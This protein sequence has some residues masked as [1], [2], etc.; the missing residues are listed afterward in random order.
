MRAAAG[1][2]RKV[3]D[4]IPRFVENPAH[5]GPKSKHGRPP[6]KKPEPGQHAGG[7]SAAQGSVAQES[8]GKQAGP[9][10]LVAKAEADDAGQESGPEAE[11]DQIA[12]RQRVA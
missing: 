12:K 7:P 11:G 3:G 5:W 9:K 2:M 6:V 1:A 4:D 8:A 10:G